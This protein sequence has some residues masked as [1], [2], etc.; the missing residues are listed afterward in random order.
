MQ[1]CLITP[2]RIVAPF[3]ELEGHDGSEITGPAFSPA[4]DRLYFSSQRGLNNQG[5]GMTFEVHG[6]FRR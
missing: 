6:P 2:E 4:G 5:V 3:L 1:I